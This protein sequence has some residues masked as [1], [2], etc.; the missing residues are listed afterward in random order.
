MTST[1]YYQRNLYLFLNKSCSYGSILEFCQ[2]GDYHEYPQHSF[3]WKSYE[4]T[5]SS[6]MN[7][8]CTFV[9]PLATGPMHKQTSLTCQHFKGSIIQDF[10][11][12]SMKLIPFCHALCQN[13]NNNFAKLLNHI[14]TTHNTILTLWRK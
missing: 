8:I 12:S 5:L 14:R 1:K 6:N 10:K 11:K 9:H 2:Q 13:I 7:I 3:S 4:T